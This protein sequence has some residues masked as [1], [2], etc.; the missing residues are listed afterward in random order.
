MSRR[1]I[2]ALIA[3]AFV[4]AG[5]CAGS[6]SGSSGATP[7]DALRVV[8]TTTVFADL[9]AQVGGSR[10]V[11]TSLV[12]KGGDV[13]TF[14]P[15][16]GTI[17]SIAEAHVVVANGL[18][19]D[20]WL[21]GV[22]R[23]AGAT[24]T[25]VTLS[26]SVPA[27]DRITDTES[28]TPNPHLWM[29]VSLARRYVES[30][31]SALTAADPA[32]ESTYAANASAYDARLAALDQA[33]RARLDRIP[34]DDRRVISFHDAFPYFARA[35]GLTVIG[36]IV[37]APGQDPSA[38][39]I[40]ELVQAVKANHVRAIIAEAQFS[41]ALVRTLA[42]ETGAGV[43]SDLYDDTL[44][45]PPVDSY[46]ALIRWDADRLVTALGG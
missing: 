36:T 26:D 39:Q 10:T 19:L 9:V 4:V 45:D 32:G 2:V 22:V 1:P 42:H 27:A 44:G 18:G 16:P 38:A 31:R 24:A 14:D 41:D 29:D 7:P 3:A 23:D 40:A 35:Y 33:T 12:P 5:A 46:E 37:D 21:V 8:A 30:I 17:R 20:G 28:G 43:V 25:V 34:A 15:T 6:R 11:V 13:H